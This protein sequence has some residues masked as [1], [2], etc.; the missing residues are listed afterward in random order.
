MYYDFKCE[1]LI[2]L[3]MDDIPGN[4]MILILNIWEW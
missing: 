2:D 1:R 4:K 3:M